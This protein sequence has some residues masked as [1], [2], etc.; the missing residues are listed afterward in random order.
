MDGTDYCIQE[1]H[2]FN[3]KWY[4]HKFWGPAVRYEIA[5]SIA[6][7][8]IVWIHG[9]FPAGEWT[10]LRIAR[11]ALNHNLDEFEMY[12]ADGGYYD[13]YQWAT[14]PTGFHKHGDRIR[15][16]VQ[17]RHENI[18]RRFKEWGALQQR[19]RHA[20]HKHRVMF[21]TIANIIQLRL[22]TDEP[23]WPIHYDEREF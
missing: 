14:T 19:W 9:P 5:I 22:E 12:I 6:T 23:A 18:N 13:G 1:Q 2:P 3:P 20:P 10:N 8:W 16:L 17:A 11:H 4:S 7:G 21:R 15:A